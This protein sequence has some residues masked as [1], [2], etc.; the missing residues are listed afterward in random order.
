VTDLTDDLSIP[1][2]LDLKISDFTSSY[3]AKFSAE[4]GCSP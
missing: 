4:G 2:F 3:P 1:A